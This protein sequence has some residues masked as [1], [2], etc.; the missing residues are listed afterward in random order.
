MP[1]VIFHTA[2]SKIKEAYAQIEPIVRN[3]IS[4]VSSCEEL[5]FPQLREPELAVK[6]DQAAKAGGARVLTGGIPV[7]SW[8]CCP[9]A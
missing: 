9:C 8:T 3:G 6:L 1:E 5:L 2:V 4:V 7:S